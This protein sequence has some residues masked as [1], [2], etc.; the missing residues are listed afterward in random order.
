M[1]KAK[2]LK[3]RVSSY[4]TK[5]T[6]LG[7]KTRILVSKINKIKTIQVATE[8]E[9]LLLE[10]NLIK[11]YIPQYNVKFT[12][13]KGY[14]F[15]R[16]TIKNEYPAVC[17]SRKTDD[18]NSLYFGPYP[19]VS[20]MRLVLKTIRV[21]F[22]FQSAINHGNRTCL[23]YHLG[24]CPCA[25]ASNS[26]EVKQN[27]KKVIRYI[28]TFLDGNIKKVIRDLEKE[29]KL[30]SKKELFEQAQEIQ[31]KIDAIHLV[32][33]TVT[34]AF[35]YVTNPNLSSDVR[36]KERAEL[37]E[38]LQHNG[39]SIQ[40]LDRIECYDIS[41][42]SGTNAVGS[43]VVFTNGEKDSSGYRRFK[44]KK[45]IGPND[46]AMMQEVIQRRLKHMEWTLPNLII[47]DG[48]KGQISSA[49]NVLNKLHLSI[50][51]IGLAKREEII[52]TSDFKE[53]KLPKD[54]SALH[55]VMRIRDEAHRF[56][57]TYHKKLRSRLTLT[58]E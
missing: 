19:N 26:Q 43:M 9:S 57:I 42:T 32:T 7:E 1:G 54:S 45:I 14:P 50:P 48:G 20:A 29:R 17:V 35:E 27:Y 47:V 8:I 5:G 13:G 28:C 31:K 40:K 23:Y 36:K 58:T 15:I 12:D 25:S 52:I 39:V 24:L 34:P 21:I 41:N 51:L 38:H 2:N 33:S 55:L 30:S 16:I 37:I 10:A 22:P 56:A 46:F 53:I 44:I 49:Q 6:L 4:F 11:K 3:A 18:P